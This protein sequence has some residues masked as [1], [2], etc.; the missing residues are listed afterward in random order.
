[1]QLRGLWD[2]ITAHS[3]DKVGVYSSAGI[4][5]SRLEQA[6]R[7]YLREQDVPLPGRQG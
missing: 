6:V 1:M 3:P 4:W 5:P 2:Y 7:D